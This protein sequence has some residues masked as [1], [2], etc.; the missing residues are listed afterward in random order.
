MGDGPDSGRRSDSGTRD[1]ACRDGTKN[2]SETD[3]DCGGTTCAPCKLLQQCGST[4]DC[5]EG[6]CRQGVCQAVTCENGA[7]DGPETDVDCGGSNCIP[8]AAGKACL[9]AK[10]CQTEYCDATQVCVVPTCTDT[11]KNQDESDTDCGGSHCSPCDVGKTCKQGGDCIDVVCDSASH[12]CLAATCTDVHRNGAETDIDCGGS[13]CGPC[14]P[15]KVCEMGSDCAQKVCGTDHVCAAAACNDGVRNGAETDVDC[16]GGTCAPCGVGQGCNAGSDCTEKVCGGDATCSAPT[17]SDSAVNESETD[18]DCGGPNCPR[19]D[20]N[21]KC[22][23]PSDCAYNV[24]SGGSCGGATSCAGGGEGKTTCGAGENED[25]CVTLPVPGGS[26]SNWSVSD[27][28]LDKYEITAGRMRAFFAAKGGNLQASPPA[29]GD[30]AHAAIANSGWQSI[31][32][33]R[34]ATSQSNIDLR[35]GVVGDIRGMNAMSG[36]FGGLD[37]STWTSSPTSHDRKSANCVDWYTLFAFCAWDGGYLPTEHEWAWAAQG[38]TE[39]RTF[40]W[41]PG[42]NDKANDFY[43]PCTATPCPD[44][45]DPMTGVGPAF[46]RAGVADGV[47]PNPPGLY[48]VHAFCLLGGDRW[49][50][51]YTGG[52]ANLTG[53]NAIHVAP[54]GHTLDNARWG[55]ADM[56]GNL[57]EWTLDNAVAPDANNFLQAK[58]Q[59]RGADCA[60]VDWIDYHDTQILDNLGTAMVRFDN[61]P[62]P[63]GWRNTHYNDPNTGVGTHDL[64]ARF[65]QDG[66]RVMRGGSWEVAHPVNVGS[67]FG[68]YPIWRAYYAAGARCARPR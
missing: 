35:V 23:S 8:C 57:I 34:L 37:A 47:F 60:N 13:T 54:P 27:Y 45:N 30:G 11:V 39:N 49:C 7:K 20:L 55:Q 10:D 18:V 6:A 22:V 26:F 12:T 56:S 2:G 63:A 25:C 4:S 14:S 38:G 15:G 51:S 61:S 66:G 67:R 31:W 62:T 36:C 46:T 5:A 17:C 65:H 24:C 19:C 44:P 16:G 53:N 9:A 40:A 52:D 68:T 58:P 28:R 64:D 43:A 33:G 48:V 50:F 32:N 41:K 3:V 42:L 21:Q 29:A 1:D 59:C